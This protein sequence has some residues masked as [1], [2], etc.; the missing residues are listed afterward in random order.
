[1]QKENK[2]IM[3]WGKWIIVSFVLF[4]GFIGTLVTVCMRAEVGLVSKDYYKE[5][6]EFQKQIVRIENTSALESKPAIVAGKGIIEITFDFSELET[7]ELILFR[8][9]DA[10]LDKKFQLST[11]GNQLQQ[12]PTDQLDPGMYRA[13][14]QWTKQGKEFYYEQVIYL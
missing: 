4:A 1:M 5:E 3:N 10:A 12:F 6:L 11:T 7:G 2:M 14:M 9:S 13:R 8:P